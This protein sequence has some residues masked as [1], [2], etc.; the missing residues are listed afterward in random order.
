MILVP[1]GKLSLSIP[2][3]LYVP[4]K[5]VDD[6]V[7]KT[8]QDDILP[9]IGCV[10]YSIRYPVTVP[11][12]PLQESV[13]VVPFRYLFDPEQTAVNLVNGAGVSGSVVADFAEDCP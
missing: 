11:A 4:L 3:S 13:T 1:A 9:S 12:V 5:L 10:A 8:F 6:I 7:F 2:L